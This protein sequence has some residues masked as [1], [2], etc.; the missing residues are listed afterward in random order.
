M[1]V[2]TVI[3]NG[4]IVLPIGIMRAG[5]AINEGKIVA[6]SHESLLPDAKRTIDAKD[7]YVIPGFVDVHTHVHGTDTLEGYIEKETKAAAFGGVTTIGVMIS[8]DPSLVEGFKKYRAAFDNNAVVDA[9]F[10]A[11]PSSVKQPEELSKC[12]ELGIVTIGEAGGY[13]GRQ[14]EKFGIA[15]LDDGRIYNLLKI[16]AKW[17]P[18]ARAL[19]HC[20]NIDIIVNLI[21]EVIKEGRRDCAAWTA[22]RPAFCEAEKIQ[23]YT[24]LA[25]ATNCPIYIVHNTCREALE[26]IRRAKS[27]NINIVAETCPQYLTLTKDSFK[28][29]PVIANVNPPLREKED[30]EALWQAIRDGTIDTVGTD[31]APVTKAQK[32]D[33]IMMAPMGLGNILATWMPAMLSYGVNQNKITLEKM[34][35]VCCYNPA[36]YMG[37]LPKK[38]TIS[39]GSDAD[40]VIVDIEKKMIPKAENLYSGSDIN[41][42]DILEVE[43]QGWPV[44]TMLRGN[45]LMENGE[46]IGEKSSG[47]YIPVKLYNK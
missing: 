14:A 31:H 38:G 24:A 8:F 19:L 4:Q 39:I 25:K 22:A 23:C 43:L 34:V 30:N 1:L 10:H 37:I 11:L 45:I 46:V 40:I 41:V 13:K 20:E 5:I 2:D 3:K 27:E 29:Y 9:V 28:N 17:G 7:K 15:Y 32:R 16:I 12:V 44:L 47:K 6:I 36:K 26:A 21:E 42:Y 33:D 35:E 18:P